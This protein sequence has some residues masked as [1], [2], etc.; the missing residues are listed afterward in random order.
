MAALSAALAAA[1]LE[2][3]IHDAGTARR[4]RRIRRECLILIRRDA[5][6]F[7]RVIRTTR[8]DERAAFRRSLK[9]ATEIPCRVFE[10]AELLQAAC[11]A[12]QRAVRPQFQSDL[13]CAMA[14]AMAAAESART[15]VLTNLAWLN[16]RVYTQQVE[17]RLQAAQRHARATSR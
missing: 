11:R 17:R 14:V 4:L 10:R 7:A 9:A 8:R 6:T 15:L 3:L 1:L 5:D 2:K 13:R 12:A 16:D